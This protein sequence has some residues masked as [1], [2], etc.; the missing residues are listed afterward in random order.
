MKNK[1]K[2][3]VGIML[4]NIFVLVGC[5]NDDE[6]VIG[7]KNFTEQYIMSEMLSILIEENTDLETDIV[8][9]L[10]GSTIHD[11][12]LSE[13]IDLYL[14]Y[15]GTALIN[16]GEEPITDPDVVYN[17]VKEYFEEELDIK[18]LEPY[19]FNNTYA[20]VVT[21][22]TAAEYNLE[23]YSDMAEV[24]DQLRLGSTHVFTERDDGYPGLIEHYDFDFASVNGMD[25]GLMYQALMTNEVDVISAFATEGR[26]P[27]FDLVILE[28]DKQ[29]FPPYDAAP[30]IR[31]EVLE[32]HPELAELLNSL[33]G[34]IDDLKMGELNAL[35]DLEGQDPEDVARDFLLEED[36]IAEN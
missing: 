1:L 13:E 7:G 32:E 11:A 21:Q 30:I 22:E 28:D 18:W 14:E 26:I 25:P 20:M 29:F 6:I 2:I 12:I 17:T 3:F 4:L 9:N 27:A 31:M 24:G 8:S 16:I 33:A 19:G 23:T 5:G 34:R 36:L 10:A 35:V 15:T